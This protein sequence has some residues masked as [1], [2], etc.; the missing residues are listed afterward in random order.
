MNEPEIYETLTR[1]F[2]DEFDDEALTISGATR[3]ADIP[4]WDS[5][6]HIQILAAVEAR[7]GI[8]IH[9]GEIESMKSVGDMVR[10]I[11][12]KNPRP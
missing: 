4:D 12:K 10:L 9:A 8:K 11:Q 2:R 1:I 6:R 7:F 5:N 3:A